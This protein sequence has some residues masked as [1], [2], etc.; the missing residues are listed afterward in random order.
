MPFASVL[1]FVSYYINRAENLHQILN[2][3]DGIWNIVVAGEQILLRD[4]L[5]LQVFEHVCKS[6]FS[7]ADF[8]KPP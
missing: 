1:F 3:I 2:F 5:L 6:A 4:C 7:R 8:G